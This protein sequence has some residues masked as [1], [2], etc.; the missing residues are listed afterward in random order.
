MSRT[1]LITGLIISAV[2][3]L[4]LFR[5]LPSN[6]F[7]EAVDSAEHKITTVDVVE[8]KELQQQVVQQQKANEPSVTKRQTEQKYNQQPVEPLLHLSPSQIPKAACVLSTAK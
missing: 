6:A 8:I 1:G 7:A 5:Y 4:W 2:L 3:H